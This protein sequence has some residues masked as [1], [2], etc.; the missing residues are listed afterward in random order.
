[1]RVDFKSRVLH[2]AVRAVTLAMLAADVVA[3]A[4][5]AKADAPAA[6]AVGGGN[7]GNQPFGRP[8]AL[9]LFRDGQRLFVTNGV[10]SSVDAFDTQTRA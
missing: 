9:V 8:A 10:A 2:R 3:Q 5:P 4:E 7:A 1:M 6:I